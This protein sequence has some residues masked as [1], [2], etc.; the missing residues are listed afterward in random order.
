MTKGLV[1][2]IMSDSLFLTA[3]CGRW[4][5]KCGLYIVCGYWSCV[6]KYMSINTPSQTTF[7]KKCFFAFLFCK[8][9]VS[10]HQW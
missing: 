1:R 3:E 6:R 2:Q 8:Y 5:Y 9:F 7:M 4:Y 10:F